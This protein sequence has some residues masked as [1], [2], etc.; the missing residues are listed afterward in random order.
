MV[1]VCAR[2]I[3]FL[4]PERVGVLL[5]RRSSGCRRWRRRGGGGGLEWIELE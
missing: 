1:S 4:Q 5:R 2:G 3:Q